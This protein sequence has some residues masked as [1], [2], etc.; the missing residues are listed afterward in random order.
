MLMLLH[1]VNRVDH[2][3]G[4]FSPTCNPEVSWWGM[5]SHT[6]SEGVPLKAL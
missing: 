3:H 1:A 4:K 2:A 6:L 5:H